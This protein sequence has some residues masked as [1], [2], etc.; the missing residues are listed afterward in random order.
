LGA[1]KHGALA[2]RATE[3]KS[4]D[5]GLKSIMDNKAINA[6]PR[7]TDPKPRKM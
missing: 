7:N 3:D 2:T 6:I 1:K 4:K 5:V